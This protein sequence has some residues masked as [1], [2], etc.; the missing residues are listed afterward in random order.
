MKLEFE[1]QRRRVIAS[2]AESVPPSLFN[3]TV[4][5][6]KANRPYVRQLGTGILFRVA[7]HRFVVTA[8]H[9]IRDASASNSTLGISGNGGH[10]VAVP[11]TWLYSEQ[12][13]GDDPFDVAVHLLTDGEV[14]KLEGKP[15][16]EISDV[17]FGE[18]GM[19][20]DE[21]ACFVLCGFPHIWATSCEEGSDEMRLKALQFS[22]FRYGG[23][24]AGL[25]GFNPRYHLLLDANDEDIFDDAGSEADFR[26]RQGHRAR[27]PHDIA[28]ASGCSVWR[29]GNPQ[30]SVHERTMKDARLVGVLTSVYAKPA[31]IKATKWVAV[32]TLL[33]AAFPELRAE[34]ECR[35]KGGKN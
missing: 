29:L 19:N 1:D 8:A 23:S 30:R 34:I 24:T 28:G 14:Q 32:T 6:V 16:L 27:W 33:H 4:I 7:N 21:R 17:S 20:E 15:F 26:L 35:P 3:S 13:G 12:S 22:A 25:A 11:G 10:F 2:I 18:D 5:V 31:L 9:A